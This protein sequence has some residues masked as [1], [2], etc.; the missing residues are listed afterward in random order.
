M[1]GNDAQFGIEAGMVGSERGCGHSIRGIWRDLKAEEVARNHSGRIEA[2]MDGRSQHQINVCSL[3]L[4]HPHIVFE[5]SIKGVSALAR[6]KRQT[7]VL[8][9]DQDIVAAIA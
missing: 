4:Q 7:L 2:T 3:P 6:I 8:S 1:R 5:I 9:F